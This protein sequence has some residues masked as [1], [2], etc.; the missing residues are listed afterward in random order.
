MAA[1]PLAAP[2]S[3]YVSNIAQWQSNNSPEVWQIHMHA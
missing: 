1:L 3:V 2:M